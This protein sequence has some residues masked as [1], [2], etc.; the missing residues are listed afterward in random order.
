MLCS[1]W[2]RLVVGGGGSDD[3]VGVSVGVWIVVGSLRPGGA[4]GRQALV[5]SHRR[6]F[7]GGDGVERGIRR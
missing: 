2:G 3:V 5:V 7:D 4:V 1:R 6:H